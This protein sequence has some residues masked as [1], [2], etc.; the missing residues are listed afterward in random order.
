MLQS[1]NIINL[2]VHL[3]CVCV[4]IVLQILSTDLILIYPVLL[5]LAVACFNC[6]LYVLL[7]VIFVTV[8]TGIG[9]WTSNVHLLY[10]IKI[11][12]SL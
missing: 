3:M 5:V 11:E 6:T 7:Y 8:V 12:C 9:G 1:N 4:C 10:L 2:A